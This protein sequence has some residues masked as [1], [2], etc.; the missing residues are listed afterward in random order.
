MMFE[1][2]RDIDPTADFALEAENYIQFI[3]NKLLITD[4]ED[5]DD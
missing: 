1:S 2:V 5:A 4:T 3:E